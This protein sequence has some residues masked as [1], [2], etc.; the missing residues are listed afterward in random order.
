M[1]QSSSG[2]DR[3]TGNRLHHYTIGNSTWLV[4]ASLV[5]A[6]VLFPVDA[7]ADASWEVV[8]EDN[9]DHSMNDG[10]VLRA[11]GREDH[12]AVVRE[13]FEVKDHGLPRC[14]ENNVLYGR[15]TDR[16]IGYGF[17]ARSPSFEELGIDNLARAY[18]MSFRYKV[19]SSEFCWTLPVASPHATLVISECSA[20][21]NQARLGV[22]D[23]ELRNFR[24]IAEINVDEWIEISI[25][26]ERPGHPQVHD[27]SIYIDD[28]LVD[29]HVRIGRSF[30]PGIVFTDLP[31]MPLDV[32]HPEGLPESPPS[33]FGSGY[34]DDVRLSVLR[35]AEDT[36]KVTRD[37]HMDP[38]PFNPATTI[39][40][41]LERATDLD[42]A[43]FDLKGR[44]VRSLHSGR[45]AAGPV[46]LRWN[47][48]DSTGREVASGTY[49]VRVRT[50]EFTRVARGVLVR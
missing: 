15:S 45:H 49:L 39:R 1:F 36:G 10:W 11:F 43:V 9:F 38:S 5:L 47:G 16:G 19:L 21:G 46:A 14:E 40:M 22:V 41:Q 32:T 4:L 7:V 33:M 35:D 44:L 27:V 31:G 2:T 50:P 26:V 13:G 34:W 3:G 20:D 29:Q 12:I 23:A 42:V 8:W 30:W 17:A 6:I 24:P 25:L 37:V 48:R 28:V 18:S